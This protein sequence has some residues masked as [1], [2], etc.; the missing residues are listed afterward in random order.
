MTERALVDTASRLSKVSRVAVGGTPLGSLPSAYGHPVEREAAVATVQRVLESP[1]NVIDTSN[2]YSDGESERRIGEALRRIGGVPPGFVLAT[3][4]DPVRGSADFTGERVRESLLESAR[5]LGVGHFKLFHLHDPERF[6]F[7]HMARPGGAIDAMVAL[8]EEGLVGAIGVAGGDIN[9]MRRYADTG[10][11]DVVLNHSQY[12]LLDQSANELVDHVIAAGMAFI[13]AAPYGSGLLAKPTSPTAHY[14]YRPAD[15]MIAAR[16]RRLDEICRR[17]GVALAA[18][19]LQF[20]TRDP[21][22]TTTVVGVST[23]ERVEQLIANDNAALPDALWPELWDAIN[24]FPV[25]A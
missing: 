8:R 23:P 15:D 7:A 14:R 13:N 16:A 1:V 24:Y 12:T 18:A 22:I 5:R 20:S 4:A 3:K 10:V 9:E 21:R 6:D 2:E 19:A 25:W 11:F 17:H